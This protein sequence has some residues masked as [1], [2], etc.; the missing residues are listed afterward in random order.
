MSMSHPTNKVAEV[1]KLKF[2][3]F[4]VEHVILNLEISGFQ[5]WKRDFQAWKWIFKVQGW[6][7]KISKV[8]L[9]YTIK[10]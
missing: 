3:D 5:S 9:S 4:K 10:S 2:E 6:N 7:F 1:C 8:K